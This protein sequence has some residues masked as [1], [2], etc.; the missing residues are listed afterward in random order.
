MGAGLAEAD[1]G[2]GGGWDDM[3][4]VYTKA[5]VRRED[6]SAEAAGAAP[7]HPEREPAWHVSR[8]GAGQTSRYPETFM[9]EARKAAMCLQPF[10]ADARE[11]PRSTRPSLRPDGKYRGGAWSQFE[12]KKRRGS[13]LV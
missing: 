8:P 3:A 6:F 12:R 7:V 1:A 10:T 5:R 13:I 2:A 11:A 4:S 9:G